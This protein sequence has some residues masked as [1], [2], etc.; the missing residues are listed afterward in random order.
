M[1]KKESVSKEELSNYKKTV[2]RLKQAANDYKRPRD[3]FG[4]YLSGNYKWTEERLKGMLEEFLVWMADDENLLPSEF[5]WKKGIK[6]DKIRTVCGKYPPLLD[7]YDWAKDGQ[8]HRL[9]KGG[10]TNKYNAALTKFI[11]VNNH[12]FKSTDVIQNIIHPD[13]INTSGDLVDTSSN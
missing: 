10:L 4:Q 1:A 6:C 12:G 13:A 2:A 5:F 7:A 3:E 9:I 11:L 8:R